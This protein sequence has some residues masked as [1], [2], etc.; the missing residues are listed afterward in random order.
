MRTA[1][2]R[3]LKERGYYIKSVEITIKARI[4]LFFDELNN[5]CLENEV[6]TEFRDR[7]VK[8]GEVYIIPND[9]DL[10]RVIEKAKRQDLKLDVDFGIIS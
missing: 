2:I 4:F 3:K 8:V 9:R 7:E 6:I 10:V 1:L 5:F